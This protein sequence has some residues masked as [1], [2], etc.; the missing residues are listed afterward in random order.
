MVQEDETDYTVKT[1]K[2][3]RLIYDQINN[4]EAIIQSVLQNLP[5]IYTPLTQEDI[6]DLLQRV[7]E[8]EEYPEK[9]EDLKED[10]HQLENF[11]PEE[12]EINGWLNIQS[13]KCI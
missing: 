9:S 12:Y 5:K 4:Q 6:K 2:I 3:Y 11:I 7:T 8:S 13:C 10:L 1:T